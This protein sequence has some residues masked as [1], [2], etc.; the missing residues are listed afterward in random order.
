MLVV[1]VT[2]VSVP[3]T[4]VDVVEGVTG[5]EVVVVTDGVALGAATVV[6]EETIVVGVADGAGLVVVGAIVTVALVVVEEVLFKRLS[7]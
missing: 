7:N 3:E 6:G 5:V 2:V 4:V 1:E